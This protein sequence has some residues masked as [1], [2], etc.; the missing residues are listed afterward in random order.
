LELREQVRDV[1]RDR[2]LGDEEI[3][4]CFTRGLSLGDLLQDILLT[5]GEM[6]PQTAARSAQVDEA[7]SRSGSRVRRG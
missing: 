1:V 3:T 4:R 6:E 2:L 5:V 7:S